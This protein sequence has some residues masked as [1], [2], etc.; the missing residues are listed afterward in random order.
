MLE[1]QTRKWRENLTVSSSMLG[2][3]PHSSSAHTTWLEQLSAAQCSG[4]HPR[5]SRGFALFTMGTNK[6]TTDGC[7]ARCSGVCPS[8]FSRRGLAPELSNF[9]Q[10]STSPMYEAACNGVL[11]PFS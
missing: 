10:I 1:E 9:L 4:V 5:I 2:S 3:A 7:L 11:K 6:D 8:L